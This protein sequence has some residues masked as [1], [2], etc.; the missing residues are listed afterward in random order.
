MFWIPSWK[1]CT[2][3]SCWVSSPFL[4]WQPSTSGLQLKKGNIIFSIKIVVF[5][6]VQ[7]TFISL[8]WFMMLSFHTMINNQEIILYINKL[9]S[10]QRL[11]VL[12]KKTKYQDLLGNPYFQRW[13][14]AGKHDIW[15]SLFDRICFRNNWDVQQ[16]ITYSF[17]KTGAIFFQTN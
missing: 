10:L 6:H 2:G 1:W 8:F 9:V 4:P 11:S 17:N 16:D 14:R 15:S 3:W 13:H 7:F 12:Q 5:Y